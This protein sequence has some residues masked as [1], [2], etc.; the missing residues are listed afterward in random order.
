MPKPRKYQLHDFLSSVLTQ[1][2]YERWLH[3]KAMAHVRRDRKR[4]N[5]TATNEAYKK[6]IHEAVACSLGRD[7]YTG[8]ALSWS[9]CSTYS[10][11]ESKS[12]R[13]HYKASLALLPTVDH[14]GD[15][16]GPAD[17]KICAWRTN[18][19]KHDLSHDEFVELC[20]LVVAHFER[21]ASIEK[22]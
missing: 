12:G 18:D 9:L 20:R 14:V 1:N 2:V 17:F 5:V 15:G 21:H 22:R 16:L 6:A 10:N 3:R 4:G 8:E 7:D 13:R 19:A 11:E